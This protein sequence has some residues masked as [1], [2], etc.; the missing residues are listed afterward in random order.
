MNR[1]T[2]VDTYPLSKIEELLVS[3]GQ[4]K[5]FTTLDFAHTYQQIPLNEESQKYEVINT[6][7]GLY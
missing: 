2:K 6:Q 1:V 4:S 7:N 5:S 3:L